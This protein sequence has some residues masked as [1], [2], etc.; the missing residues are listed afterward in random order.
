MCRPCTNF[1]RMVLKIDP[2]AVG[3]T[4]QVLR[5]VHTECHN[6]TL[7]AG[8]LDLF[9]G[10]CH[11]QNGLHILNNATLTVTISVNRPLVALTF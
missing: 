3:R 4:E 11:G 7:T 10:H 9:D 5:P 6:V 2:S 1:A 8:T